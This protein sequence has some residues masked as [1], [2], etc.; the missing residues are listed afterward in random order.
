MCCKAFEAYL[1]Y[2]TPIDLAAK[3]AAKEAHPTTHY[4]W[5]TQRDGKVRPSHRENAGKIFAW[6]D[7]PPTGHPGEDYGCRC[8]A[9][10]YA[11]AAQ[12]YFTITM[13]DVSDEGSPWGSADFV[14]HYF[15]G[16]GRTVTLRE[17]GT[18]RAVVAEFRKLAVDVPTKLPGQIADKAREGSSGSF[19]DRFGRSYQMQKIVFS[20]GDTTIE[21]PFK[22]AAKKT[23]AMLEL[24]GEITFEQSDKFRDPVDVEEILKP[25][26]ERIDMLI[27]QAEADNIVGSGAIQI[28]VEALLGR[29]CLGIR[30]NSRSSQSLHRSPDQRNLE[31]SGQ[32][33]HRA[34]RD[35]IRYCRSVARDVF[36][37]SVD[38][39]RQ[40]PVQI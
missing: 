1:R 10:P 17:T 19:E 15:F 37:Q 16:G 38:G 22:G 5:R 40:E 25:F 7:P 12:E 2:G 4:I 31:R 28:Y 11:P 35:A 27:R 3:A 32:H 21:G 39:L 6:D 23:H 34:R 18:L 26:L 9:E 8:W 29:T 13:Q 33:P 14:Y 36:G 20:L 24:N 30:P